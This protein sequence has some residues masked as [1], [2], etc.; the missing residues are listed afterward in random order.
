MCGTASGWAKA[1]FV[2][3]IIGTALHIAGW[4]T[5]FWLVY[6][7][8]PDIGEFKQ[9]M[10]LWWVEIC[11]V[12]SC[13]LRELDEAW[14]NDTVEAIRAMETITFCMAIFGTVF[15]GVYIFVEG[16][17]TRCIAIVLLVI[18]YIMGICSMIGMI[19]TIVEAP[20]PFVVSW[21]LG[22]TVLAFLLFLIA[23]TLLIPDI[24]EP[25]EPFS[26]S[27]FEGPYQPPDRRGAITPV[28]MKRNSADFW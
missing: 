23:G 18:F 7:L 19:I 24:F 17:R 12:L 21:S 28:S 9:N 10:G 2:C 6:E 1:A 27:D 25:R 4:A 20:N 13:T 22:L 14:V 11:N 26:Q 15:L 5:N 3:A 8:D 16:T